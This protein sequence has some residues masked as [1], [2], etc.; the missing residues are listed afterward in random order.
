MKTFNAKKQGHSAAEPQSKAFSQKETKET[1]R[2]KN[3]AKSEEFSGIAP[4][5]TRAKKRPGN[6]HGWHGFRGYEFGREMHQNLT[7]YA[8]ILSSPREERVG[9]GNGRGDL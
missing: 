5:S 9:R 4:Q 6:N 7:N 3:F 8:C 1:K 2:G